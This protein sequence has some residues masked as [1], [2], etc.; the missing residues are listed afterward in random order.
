MKAGATIRDLPDVMTPNQAAAA[1]P[2][3]ANTIRGLCKCGAIRAVKTGGADCKSAR[4]LISKAALI[5][6]LDGGITHAE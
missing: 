6:W 1:V 3:S 2:L 4:W 5:D